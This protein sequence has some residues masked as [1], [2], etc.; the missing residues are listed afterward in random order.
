MDLLPEHG[1]YFWSLLVG[2]AVL[3]SPAAQAA[4]R[5]EIAATE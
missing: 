4:A 5:A 3:K 1:R 2:A